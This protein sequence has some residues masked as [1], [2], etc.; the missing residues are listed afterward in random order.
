MVILAFIKN[1]DC[2]RTFVSS[3][4]HVFFQFKLSSIVM[5]RK[6]NVSTLSI[7]VAYIL[8]TGIVKALLII[9][10]SMYFDLLTLRD[11]LF[12]FNNSLI[13]A[14]SLFIGVSKVLKV[15]ECGV[16]SI[17]N[18]IKLCSCLCNVI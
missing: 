8:S 17:H 3:F 15:L 10:Y 7:T 6:F 12:I 16:I 4:F 2:F 9:L 18:T 13:L 5:P 1:S 14:N 11:N